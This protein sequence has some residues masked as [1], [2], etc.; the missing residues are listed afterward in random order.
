MILLSLEYSRISIHQHA[1]LK[2]IAVILTM[3]IHDIRYADY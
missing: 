1:S 3:Q 2:N